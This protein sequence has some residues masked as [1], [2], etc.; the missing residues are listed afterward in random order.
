ME[1]KKPV[2]PIIN[3]TQKA[4]VKN[5]NTT[6]TFVSP[7]EK[8]EPKISSPKV[9]SNEKKKILTILLIAL[10]I[11]IATV[12]VL[13]VITNHKT[14]K[15]N[16]ISIKLS[17][18][19]DAQGNT[20]NTGF[21]WTEIENNRTYVDSNGEKHIKLL[22]G[23]KFGGKLA[24]TSL[25][26]ENNPTLSGDVVVRCRVYAIVEDRYIGNI[27]K[28]TLDNENAN[29]WFSSDFDGYMYYNNLLSTDET[30]FLNLTIEIS[31]AKTTNELQGK[32]VSLFYSFEVLQASADQS[33]RE[34]WFS[35]PYEW[36]VNIA[37]KV[38]NSK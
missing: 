30:I 19:Q 21:D 1:P 38:L 27:F 6:S 16:D 9:A 4:E 7:L 33:I 29:D 36:R 34:M 17:I 12:V 25:K 22:P 23:D 8:S 15:I 28:Y 37:N 2:F 11:I 3:N 26:D 31:G 13:L 5:I 10:A 24:L 14:Q 32:R 20:L 35:S 18:K